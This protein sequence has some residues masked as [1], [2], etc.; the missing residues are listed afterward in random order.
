MTRMDFLRRTAGAR[1]EVRAMLGLV[2][3]PLRF[4][5]RPGDGDTLIS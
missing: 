5:A 2:G 3:N 1:A 4:L